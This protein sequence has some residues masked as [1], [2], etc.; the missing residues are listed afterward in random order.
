[1]IGWIVK[2]T[3]RSGWRGIRSRLRFAT[4]AVSLTA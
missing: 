2:E 4:T 1:M 3:Q